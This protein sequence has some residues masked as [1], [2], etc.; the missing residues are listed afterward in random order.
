[1]RVESDTGTNSVPLLLEGNGAT[2][3]KTGLIIEMALL[4]PA[5]DGTASLKIHNVGGF[6]ERID[7]GTLLGNAEEACV[8]MPLVQQYDVPGEV[9][10]IRVYSELEDQSRRTRLMLLISVLALI[11]LC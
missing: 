11:R 4:Q 1:M 5:G 3:K 6:T 2:C 10:Q 9:R 7:Q 8:M